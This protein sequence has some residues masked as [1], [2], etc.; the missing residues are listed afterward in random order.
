MPSIINEANGTL[1]N[2][3]TRIT[4]ADGST[5]MGKGPKIGPD[6]TFWYDPA[7]NNKYTASTSEIEKIV[8]LKRGRGAL[9]GLKYG[10]F[11]GC[12]AGLIV[13]AV[14]GAPLYSGDDQYGPGSIL[15]CGWVGAF[16]AGVIGLPIGAIVGSKD[17]YILIAPEDSSLTDITIKNDH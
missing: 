3:K 11:I 15:A 2:Q 4:L 12:T 7:T 8:T 13:G 5:L 10:A 16:H 17:E 6:S 14:G 1:K 9:E